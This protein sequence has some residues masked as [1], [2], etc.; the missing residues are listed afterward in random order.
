MSH[1]ER[2]GQRMV[3]ICML[4]ALLFNFPVLALFNVAGTLFG[5]P[6]LYAFIFAAW[7][8]VIALM[9]VV[10]DFDG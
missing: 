1:P 10:V 7:A 2:K 5:I 3:A 8:A 9:A 4:G 6:L